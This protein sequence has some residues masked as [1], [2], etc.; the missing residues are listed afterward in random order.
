MK[1]LL[2]IFAH[3]DD[4]SHGPGTTLAKYAAEGVKVYYLCATRG[5][6]GNVDSRFLENNS[7]S[8]AELR[9]TLLFL[10]R[11]PRF[12]PNFTHLELSRL[13]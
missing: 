9:T 5:E 2:V 13:F 3:P 1:T 4:E 10:T 7:S 12:Y 6:A 11:S 8:V